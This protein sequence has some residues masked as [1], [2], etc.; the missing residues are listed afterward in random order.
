MNAFNRY[1]KKNPESWLI[2]IG[3][4]GA[5]YESSV[6]H[7][8]TLEASEHIIL[9]R[10]MQNP[11]PVLKGCDLFLLSSYYEGYP[12]V[13]LEAATLGVPMAACDVKGCHGFLSKHGGLLLENS[14]SGLL[15]GMQLFTEGQIPPLDIDADLINRTAAAQVETLI[16]GDVN[17][18][19]RN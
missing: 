3:G 10:S 13:L 2:L 5:L 15:H 4:S 11:M 12:I 1:W 6:A 14:E 18:S 17:R 7:A 16:A 9:I 8:Q 19:S